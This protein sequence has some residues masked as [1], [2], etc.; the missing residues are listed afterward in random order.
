MRLRHQ[1]RRLWLVTHPRVVVLLYHRVAEVSSDP[2]LLC[3]TPKHFEEHI[4]YLRLHY[5]LI[6]LW[7]L[8]QSLEA[9]RIPPKAVVVTFD[10]GYAD[11]LYNAKPLLERYDVPATVFVTTGYLGGRRGFWWDELERLLLLA[12][13][14]PEHLQINLN[15]SIYE[16]HLGEWAHLPKALDVSYQKWNVE[17]GIDPTPRHV[18]YRKLCQLLRPLNEETRNKVLSYLGTQAVF[19]DGW[20][21]DGRALTF[22]ELKKLSKGELVKIGAHAVTHPM[23]AAQSSELQRWEIIESKRRLETIL[24]RL[25][26]SFSYP[27]GGQSD[28]N[29][30]TIAFVREAGY[31]T[32]CANVPGVIRKKIN[33]YWIP[34][35]LV[36]DWGKEEFARSL[37][38]FFDG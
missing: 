14:L 34:R 15:G 27:Y 24:R 30:N 11:N 29:E 36:R 6:N 12:P 2:Q 3:I 25:V 16:W 7:D 9:G 18:A 20:R 13:L 31:E 38:R 5:R 22:E 23:L 1:L 37:K 4:E 17:S 19:P 28:V 32:A 35:F 10:D 8:K 26:T 21:A 33:P